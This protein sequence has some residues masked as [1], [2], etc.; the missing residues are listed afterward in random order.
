METIIAIWAVIFLLI[1]FFVLRGGRKGSDILKQYRR[2]RIEEN[3]TE[4]L[5]NK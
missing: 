3:N 1:G 5:D 4:I 2:S